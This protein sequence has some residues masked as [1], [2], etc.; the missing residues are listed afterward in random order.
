MRVQDG[1]G[2]L[3]EE[4]GVVMVSIPIVNLSVLRY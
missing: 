4:S 1:I 3:R 2:H